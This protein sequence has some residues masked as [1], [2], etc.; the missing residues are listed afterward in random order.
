MA[1]NIHKTAQGQI[2]D[3]D[4]MRLL[5]ETEISLGNMNVNSRGD[6]VAADGTII[7]TRQEVMKDHYSHTTPTQPNGKK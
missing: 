6:Q 7:K 1:K 2:V 5:H 4:T 3:M